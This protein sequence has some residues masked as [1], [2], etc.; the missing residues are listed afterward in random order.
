[1]RADEFRAKYNTNAVIATK[2]IARRAKDA[3]ATRAGG[4]F[5]VS[6]AANAVDKRRASVRTK[7]RAVHAAIPS[8]MAVALHPDLLKLTSATKKMEKRMAK[9]IR[10]M[11]LEKLMINRREFLDVFTNLAELTD[12][13]VS[14]THAAAP[15]T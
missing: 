15:T 1:M 5:F 11:T 8:G 10:A 6:S 9:D 4:V 3:V 14:S 12:N 2:R 7:K 13:Q